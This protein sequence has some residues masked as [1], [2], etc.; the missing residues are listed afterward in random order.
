MAPNDFPE[1]LKAVS[2]SE[3]YGT[4]ILEYKTSHAAILFHFD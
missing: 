4:K 2:D 1:F 3:C